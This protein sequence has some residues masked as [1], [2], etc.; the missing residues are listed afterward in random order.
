M[1]ESALDCLHNYNLQDFLSAADE[2]RG[3]SKQ[4][5]DPEILK[6]KS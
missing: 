3:A 1:F 5:R 4:K 6:S 2:L